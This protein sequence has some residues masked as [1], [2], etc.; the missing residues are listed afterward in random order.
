MTNHRYPDEFDIQ[1]YRDL[2]G[3]LSDMSEEQAAF[4]CLEFG[5]DEGRRSHQLVDRTAFCTLVPEHTLEIGPVAFPSLKGER[6]EYADIFSTEE[7]R[8]TAQT[9]G[10]DPH[11]VPVINHVV[12]PTDLSK[13]RTQY[14]GVFS[15]HVIEHQPDL[16]KHLQ[17]ISRLL[18]DGGSYLLAVPDH[19]YCFDHFKP[20]STIEEILGAH[21]DKHKWHS[22]RSVIQRLTLLAHNDS[23]RH[24]AGDHGCLGENPDYPGLT[25][26]QLLRRS[27]DEF[28][29]WDGKP[30]NE[31]SWFFTP[32]SFRSIISDVNSLG[33]IALHLER[34][35]PTMRDSIEFW[36]ILTKV[37]NGL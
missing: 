9:S 13:I 1:I 18:A 36:V 35:Y 26:A 4:H 16:I 31:H 20:T 25:R 22:A 23:T 29:S 37:P 33:L 24:W 21:L 32:R 6:V 12:E 11:T 3:D 15:S 30:P 10:F 5:E 7:L 17:Q 2:Y 28:A 27:M 14:E 34:L 8:E 19:R